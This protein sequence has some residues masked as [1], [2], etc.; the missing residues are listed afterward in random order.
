MRYLFGFI[1]FILLIIVGLIFVF[2]DHKKPTPVTNKPVILPLQEYATSDATVSMTIDGRVNGED[3]HR[4]IRITVSRDSRTLDIIQGYSGR[5]AETHSF[6][7][8]SDAYDVFLRSLKNS[9][10]MVKLKKPTAPDDSRGYCP[11]G[12]R[13]T[14]VLEKET[15]TLSSLWSSSCGIGTFGGNIDLVNGLFRDQITDYDALTSQVEL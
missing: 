10:F 8:S 3:A 2:S 15:D 5:V 6:S 14:L 9:G 7:N 13:T 12:Q 11:D 4:A 1:I